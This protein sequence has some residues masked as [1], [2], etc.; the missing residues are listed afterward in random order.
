MSYRKVDRLTRLLVE[1]PQIRQAQVANVELT[2]C[3]LPNRKACNAQ[4]ID[5]FRVAIEKSRRDQISQEAVDGA[6]GQP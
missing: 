3:R 6:Y 2:G 5:A 4:T 1:F